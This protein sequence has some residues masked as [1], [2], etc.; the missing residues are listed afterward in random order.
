MKLLHDPSRRQFSTSLLGFALGAPALVQA[1][2]TNPDF[3]ALLRQGGN[4]LLMRH[5]QTVPGIGD[6]PNFKLGDCSTQRNL[7]E[8]GREQSRRVAAAFQRENIAP[9]DVRSS[10]WC[11]CVDT[12][13]LA[14]G[15]HTV[16][17]PINSFFQRSGREPQTLEVLQALKTFKAPRNLVL[18]THQVSISALTGSFVAMGEILLTRPG[19]LTDGRLRVLARQSF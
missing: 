5:A 7:N 16:W 6:P 18:V 4:V 3:W 9:D 19:Q 8:V 10:A 13:D 17:S 15:R 2:E 12:A 11:R 1:Q 14:F